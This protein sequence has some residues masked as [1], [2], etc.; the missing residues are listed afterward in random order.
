MRICNPIHPLLL[1]EY[2]A[3]RKV[4][5]KAEYQKMHLFLCE[6]QHLHLDT[7]EREAKEIFQQ[8]KESELRMIQ[9]K[10]SLKDMYRELTERCHKPDM[11][12]LQV[13]RESPSSQ[14][15]ILLGARWPWH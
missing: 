6:D 11:E 8:L 13:R 10:E 1:Q 15:G 9:Q 2:V 14:T 5:I 7:M 3:L 4:M 12:L